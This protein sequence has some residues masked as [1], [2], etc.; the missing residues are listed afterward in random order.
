MMVVRGVVV[1]VVADMGVE[2]QRDQQPVLCHTAYMGQIWHVLTY[3]RPQ[4]PR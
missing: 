4:N 3:G 1:V 2:V